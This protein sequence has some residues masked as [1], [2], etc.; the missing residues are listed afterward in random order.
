[1][2]VFLW[3]ERYMRLHKLTCPNCGG[4]LEMKMT[5]NSDS[6]FCPYCGQ[7]FFVDDEKKTY[8]INQNINVNKNIKIDKYL[9]VILM[10]SCP[11]SRDTE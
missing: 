8:T 9:L 5:G 4:M 3:G 11:R 7:Q 2:T 10:F 6:I 1:M